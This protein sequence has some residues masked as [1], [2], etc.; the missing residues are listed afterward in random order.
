MKTVVKQEL[1]IRSWKAAGSKGH[2]MY[3]ITEARTL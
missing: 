3:A 1:D 2:L